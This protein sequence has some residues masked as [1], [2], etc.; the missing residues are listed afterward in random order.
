LRVLLDEDVRA[1]NERALTEEEKAQNNH[2]AEIGGAIIEGGIA[3][4][5]GVAAGEGSH[6]LSWIWYTV[7]VGEDSDEKDPRFYDGQ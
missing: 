7:G 1:L 2:W 3:R 6:S 4:A 5:A